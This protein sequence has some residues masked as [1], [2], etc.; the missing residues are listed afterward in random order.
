MGS[1]VRQITPRVDVGPGTGLTL[2]FTSLPLAGSAIVITLSVGGGIGGSTVS[3]VTDNQG[4]GVNT[5]TSRVFGSDVSASNAFIIACDAIAAPS[6][7]FSITLAFSSN[8][9]ASANALEWTQPLS[10]PLDKTGNIASTASGQT[11]ATVTASAANANPA[12]LVV[13]VLANNGTNNTNAGITD[14]A[15]TGYTTIGVQQNVDAFIG[16]EAAYKVLAATE[17]SSASWSWTGGASNST[18]AAIAT[19]KGTVS[20]AALAGTPSDASSAS[21][22]LT[23]DSVAQGLFAAWNVGYVGEPT[24]HAINAPAVIATMELPNGQ[25]RQAAPGVYV[26]P[27][28]ILVKLT[29]FAAG[30]TG[31]LDVHDCGS[32]AE[33]NGG[34]LVFQIAAASITAGVDIPVGIT[35]QTGIVISSVPSGGWFGVSFDA[36]DAFWP[37]DD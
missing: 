29:P 28:G 5:Y 10:S 19:F 1:A 31:T 37:W 4:S 21:S 22:T 25:L 6:G 9:F 3:S 32:L 12:D 11:S 18:A 24:R 13:A 34:N 16:Y 30:S 36:P 27:C 2:T 14:P 26:K 35:F 15:T 8:L 23:E 17:T 33:A 20:G 7:T